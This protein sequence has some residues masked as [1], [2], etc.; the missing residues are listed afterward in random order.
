[1]RELLI[2]QKI[3]KDKRSNMFKK[4]QTKSTTE[5]LEM[6]FDENISEPKTLEVTPT[7][8]PSV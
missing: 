6:T 3:I 2:K 1:M 5:D 8:E 4:K 7:V